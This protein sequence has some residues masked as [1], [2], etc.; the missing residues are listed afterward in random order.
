MLATRRPHGAQT[1]TLPLDRDRGRQE[2]RTLT[3]PPGDQ[4]VERVDVRCRQR[5]GRYAE[6]EGKTVQYARTQRPGRRA[7]H[8][9]VERTVGAERPSKY[10]GGESVQILRVV[11]DPGGGPGQAGD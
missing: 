4:R 7:Q 6:A 1:A 11:A 2:Y 9:R 5:A 10:L 3:G 8:L